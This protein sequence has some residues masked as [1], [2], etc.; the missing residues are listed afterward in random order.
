MSI[1]KRELLSVLALA[2]FCVAPLS[3]QLE[4]MTLDFSDVTATNIDQNVTESNQGNEKEVEF[5]DYDLDGD[6]DAMVAVGE[7]DFGQR[8]NKL[9][10]NDGGVLVEVSGAPVIPGFSFTD[11]SRSAY[12]RDY[13]GDND[14]DII[15]INDSNS[16]DGG[17]DSPGKTKLFRND[18]GIFVNV[19]QN[20]SN[21]RGA[22]CNG[23]SE[24][25]DNNGTYDLLM[26]NYPNVS[27]D[28]L[29]LNGID[30]DAEGIFTVVTRDP[31]NAN[32][33]GYYPVEFEY[34]VHSE[35]GDMNGDGLLDILMANWTGD[36]SFI[37]YNNNNG[38]GDGPGDFAYAGAGAS[39]TFSAIGGGDERAMVPVDVNGDGMLDMYFANHSFPGAPRGDV[40]F[41]NTG[42]DGNN[43]A[44]FNLSFEMPAVHNAET[45]KITCDDLDNDGKED[46]IIMSEFLRPRVYRNLTVGNDLLLIDW[47]TPN[48]TTALEGW[49][50]N[51]GDITGNGRRDVFFGSDNNDHLFENVQST[52]TDFD[53]L[54]N[55]QLPGFHDQS[56]IAISGTLAPGESKFLFANSVLPLNAHVAVIA[57]STGDI[58]LSASIGATN[59]GTSDRKGDGIAEGFEF[60]VTSAGIVLFEITNNSDGILL[61]DLNGDGEFN[62]LDVQPFVDLLSNSEFDPAADFNG[63][64]E[65]SLLDVSLF[66][67]GLTG[68]GGNGGGS[69]P[70]VIEFLSQ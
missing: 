15:I 6:L 8:R 7:G 30:G 2:C 18:N 25:F 69:V 55:G 52:I 20:L 50:A 13:D 47:T 16:G 59:V 43:K 60:D 22:A 9:Y 29:A 23:V 66:V 58:G 48:I 36:P 40:V 14:L 67:E 35:A 38:Q 26:C 12:F 64:G 53:A 61:G 10:R 65:V 34:G 11:T 24:D 57:R 54:T 3:A 51:S 68:G 32:L 33:P 42:N 31:N 17:N 45:H 56:P 49:H 19:S 4:D 44:T 39:T 1:T 28:S 41:F 27:Q 62:L 37:Y 70:F 46:F 63:D 5:G 21:V